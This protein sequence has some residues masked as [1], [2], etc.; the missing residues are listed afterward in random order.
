MKQENGSG[1]MPQRGEKGRRKTNVLLLLSDQQR[2]DTI[3]AAGFPH[4]RT[5]NLDRLAREGVLFEQCHST[6]PVCMACRHDLIT[7]RPGRDHGY[8]TNLEDKP[9]DHYDTPTLPRIFSE[10]G[11]RTAAV[12]KMHFYPAREHHGF[13]EMYLMEELPR[14][15]QDDQY[16]MYLKEKGLGDVQNQHG[17][18][19][20]LYHVP[21]N[22][23]QSLAEHGTMWT[24]DRSI[25]WL[26]ENGEEPFFLM[27]GFIQPHPPWN[28]PAKLNDLYADVKLPPPV[29]RSRMPMD[30]N[31]DNPWFGDRDTKEQKEAIRRAYYTAVSMVDAAAG[32]ILDALRSLGLLDNTLVIFTSD[33][34]EMLQDKG[35][36]S[37]ELAYEGS[38]RVPLLLRYPDRL[39]MGKKV[40]GFVDTFDLLPTCLDAC[41]LNYPAGNMRGTSLLGLAGKNGRK[42]Q[43]SSSGLGYRRWVMC[44]NTEYKYIYHYNGGYEEL[45]NMQE[46]AGEQ[47]NLLETGREQVRVIADGLREEAIR[48]ETE[49]GPPDYIRGGEFC[50]VPY[51]PF[52]GSVR[53]KY[54]YWANYQMQKFYEGK[55]DERLLQEILHAADN[56]EKSGVRLKALFNGRNWQEDFCS[57]FKAY[58]GRELTCGER[59]LLFGEMQEDGPVPGDAGYYW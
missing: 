30:G 20:L 11:Y 19:P 43:F 24:A 29:P 40:S 13:G 45:Y 1:P 27:C 3:N 21:Q 15:R 32:K 8:Y 54:H 37:K 52:H 47:T 17:V 6:N 10:N 26:K 5:P 23:A 50:P 35:Y 9:I 34:G 46:D 2:Y 7:G 14:R 28:I 53:G 58:T 42:L 25:Q 41:G 48:Y 12:G 31:D 51:K 56:P 59:E 18:R 55:R 33:H 38:V 4:M 57:R 49:C 39:P 44:R 36:Y 16:A 22:S